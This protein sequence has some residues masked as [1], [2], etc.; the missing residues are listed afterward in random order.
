VDRVELDV[1]SGPLPSHSASMCTALNFSPLKL[2]CQPTQVATVVP[3]ENAT[4]EHSSFRD[5]QRL[6]GTLS[7]SICCG[8]DLAYP[9]A[10][11]P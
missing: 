9:G 11:D 2:S 5:L 7:L 4:I 8:A 3:V 1:K 10:A 6:R